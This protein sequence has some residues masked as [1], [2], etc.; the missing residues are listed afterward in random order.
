VA[1]PAWVTGGL[2]AIMI[3]IAV[4]S[5]GRLAFSR[6]QRR[7]TEL[8]ADALHV[9][10]GVAMAG[11][12]VPG[13]SPL[14]RTA[15]QVTFAVAAA[16]FAGQ[17]LRARRGSRPRGS[18]C[19]YPA[20]HFVECAAMIYMLLPAGGPRPPGSASAMAMPGMSGPSGAGASFPVLALV[21]A[22]FMLGYIFWTADRLTSLSRSRVTPAARG[23]APGQQS[24]PTLPAAAAAAVDAGHPAG[25]AGADIAGR[26]SLAARPAL[27]PRLAACCKIAMGLVM[28]YMLIAM[29]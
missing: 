16:W 26:A 15:W 3:V 4:Y 18:R 8:D 14:P 10:M 12:L 24:L 22:M 7:E 9:L 5:A 29:L 11:M 2:A 28:G 21:L 19:A 25:A 6:L 23:A 17:A 13:L 1:R 27:A 20:A